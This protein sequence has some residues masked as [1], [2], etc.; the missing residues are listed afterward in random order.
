M[1]TE[2]EDVVNCVP[3]YYLFTLIPIIIISTTPASVIATAV[4]T[5][6]FLVYRV[7]QIDMPHGQFGSRNSVFNLEALTTTQLS[8]FFI[9]KCALFKWKD[10][11]RDGYEVFTKKIL[12]HSL[13]SGVL[14]IFNNLNENLTNEELNIWQNIEK[15]LLNNG[16]NVPIYFIEENDEIN[17]L[18]NELKNP[19]ESSKVTSFREFFTKNIFFDSY[20]LVI[21]GPPVTT[22]NNPIVTS[23]QVNFCFLI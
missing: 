9:R 1:L 10:L 19:I 4:N 13:V 15:K 3:F 11:L 12:Q 23:F 14:I 16:T 21:N 8:D 22:V 6:Q 5:N 20:Q 18:Y 17:R 7:H 2:A